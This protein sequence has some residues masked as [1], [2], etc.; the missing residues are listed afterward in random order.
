MNAGIKR[1][2]IWVQ[3]KIFLSPDWFVFI[4]GL[5]SGMVV[6]ILFLEVYR[7]SYWFDKQT[8]KTLY[9]VCLYPEVVY[10]GIDIYK[11]YVNIAITTLYI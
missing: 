8:T 9:V 4:C 10:L 2:A 3:G 1:D 11:F 7:N 5:L 6:C